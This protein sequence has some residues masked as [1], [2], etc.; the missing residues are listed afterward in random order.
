[1]VKTVF[2]GA[3]VPHIFATAPDAVARNANRTLFC[4]N[5]VLYSYRYSAPI[6]AWHGGK[7]LLNAD[8]YSVTTSKHQAWTRRAV[9]HLQ[10]VT[11]PDLR[12]VLENSASKESAAAYIVK[13]T[14]EIDALRDKESRARAEYRKR[15]IAGE[16]A[17]LETACEF[18]WRDISQQKTP[19]QNAIAIDQKARDNAAIRRYAISRNRLESGLENAVRI[20]ESARNNIATDTTRH[21][22]QKWWI[23]DGAA[24]DIRRLDE[25]GANRGLG[26]GA[27][28][29]FTDAARLLGK[30]WA[31][32][33]TKLAVAIHEF[34]ASLQT[35]IDQS[36]AAYDAAEKVKNAET[37]AA[38][39]RGENVQWPIAG[40]I[41]CR[42]IGGDTVETSHGARVPLTGA[43]MLVAL[44]S[45]CRANGLPMDLKGRA[46]GPY[47]ATKIEPDG[48]LIVGCH[49]IK[50]DAIADAVARYEA[51]KVSA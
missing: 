7:I 40:E 49:R 45:Q 43:L 15:A 37:V 31:N 11:L 25:M 16:I 12:D 2:T 36:R 47:R 26:I 42:V 3:E 23:L 24:K 29:T 20:L 48:T 32:E 17:A 28:A 35:E 34:A 21:G 50:W 8:S 5:G 39:Y 46:I 38:W 14:K 51:G 6:A 10:T 44:A 18:V 9:S 33:S 30:K 4:E 19:W 27:T 22:L 1:M 41:V 13:R